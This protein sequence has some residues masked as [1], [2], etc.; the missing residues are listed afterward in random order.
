MT[1]PT[2]N[3][4]NPI[5]TGINIPTKATAITAKYAIKNNFAFGG[6]AA[7]AVVERYED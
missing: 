3:L 4:I 7:C 5:D 6:R 1:P 2:A